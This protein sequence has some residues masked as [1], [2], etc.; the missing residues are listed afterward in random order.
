MLPEAPEPNTELL[1]HIRENSMLFRGTE[2]LSFHLC[3]ENLQDVID[4]SSG[5]LLSDSKDV[6]L[7]ESLKFP[8]D[9]DD[10]RKILVF[11]VQNVMPRY[12]FPQDPDYRLGRTISVCHGTSLEGV[13][14]VFSMGGVLMRGP[15]GKKIRK[16]MRYAVFG[17]N[18]RTAVE[19]A[20]NCDGFLFVFV[21]S[22]DQGVKVGGD[23]YLFK[24]H[25]G[26]RDAPNHG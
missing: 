9:F 15:R 12:K 24:E 20:S 16:T 5:T 23:T 3:R 22:I 17:G 13:L 25:L 21:V 11:K 4:W 18:W 26:H 8:P 10:R 19:Y 6:Q 1:Q 2:F 7:D 14:G